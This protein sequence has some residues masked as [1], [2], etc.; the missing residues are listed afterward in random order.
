MLHHCHRGGGGGLAS[1][2]PSAVQCVVYVP[3]SVLLYLVLVLVLVLACKVL[4]LV[5][6]LESLVLVLVLVL[7]T[8]YLL[9]RKKILR[10]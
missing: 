6:V 2:H 1:P 3:S 4:V 9:P 10:V 8:K 5:L 7:V